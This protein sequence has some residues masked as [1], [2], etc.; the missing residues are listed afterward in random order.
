MAQIK[1]QRVRLEIEWSKGDPGNFRYR[2]VAWGYV[3][4]DSELAGQKELLVTGDYE[5]IDRD[6]FRALTGQQIENNAAA[7]ADEALQNIGFGAG[8]HTIVDDLE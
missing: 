6:A 3:D 4:D 7:L 1:K 2:T 5:T 8:H